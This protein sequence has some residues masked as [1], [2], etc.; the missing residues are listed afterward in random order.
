MN[1]TVEL[2]ALADSLGE[3]AQQA[4]QRIVQGRLKELEPLGQRRAELLEQLREQLARQSGTRPAGVDQA[5]AALQ[6]DAEQEMALL[7]ALRAEL[8]AA[9]GTEANTRRALGAYSR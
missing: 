1:E 8:A 6:R 5:L 3:L 2:L 7:A 4:R 9:I